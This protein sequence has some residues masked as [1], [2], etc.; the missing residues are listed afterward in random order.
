MKPRPTL[1]AI[2]IAS[3][4]AAALAYQ[5]RAAHQPAANPALTAYVPQ[6]AL[7]TIESPD[8]AALLHRWQSSPEAA[9]WLHSA[10]HSVFENSRLY[11]RLTDAEATFSKAAGIPATD[12]TFLNQIAGGQSAFAWYDIGKLEFLYITRIPAEQSSQSQL[13]QQRGAYQRRHAG[14]ADFYIRPGT[15]AYSTVAFAQVSTPSGDLLLLATREDLIAN[16]LKLLAGDKSTAPVDQ[17]TWFQSASAALPAEKSPPALHMLLNL[18]RIA[19]DPHFETYWIQRNITWTRQYRA[20]VS[21]LYLEPTTFREERALISKSATPETAEADVTSLA[22]LAPPETG[23]ARAV[24]TEDPAVAITAIQEKLL[25]AQPTAEAN[26]EQAPDPTLDT[27]QAGSAEDLETRIDTPPP[28][29]PTASTAALRQAI[30]AAHLDAILTL[31]SADPATT[32]FVPIHSGVVLHAT[33]AWNPESLAT[34][35]Q[36]TLRGAFTAANLGIEFHPTT[37][38][39]HAI[40]SLSGPHPLFLAIASTATQGNLALLADNQP[41]LLQ[42]LNSASAPAPEPTTPATY[43]ATFNHTTQRAPYARLTSLIDSTNLAP[44]SGASPQ[45]PAFFSQNIGSL[46]TT[47]ASL[48]SERLIQAPTATSLRQTV[49]YQW[50]PSPTA[51]P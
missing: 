20:A 18:D 10:N 3:L 28:A 35:L 36:Q 6:G 17:E 5:T 49:L 19:H 25:G 29:A 24:A 22:A 41:L 16:A 27:A 47:F 7:L 11:G 1:L 2:L 40:Y 4:A 15:E 42:L 37:V 9:A 45:T 39:G 50:R 13:L 23:L 51:T 12:T 48:Q 21:D 38:S 32:L 43:I 14:D 30:A 31:A 46:S 34:A 8:F 44:A 33:S 26:A